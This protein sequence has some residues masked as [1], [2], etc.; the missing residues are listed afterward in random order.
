MLALMPHGIEATT[1]KTRHGP[2]IVIE[3]RPVL[4]ATVKV[5]GVRQGSEGLT[6]RDA[7]VMMPRVATQA[8]EATTAA[9]LA[10]M[11]GA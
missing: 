2:R 5:S 10:A 3:T 11:R 8:D 7:V 9:E 6:L 1:T 4:V